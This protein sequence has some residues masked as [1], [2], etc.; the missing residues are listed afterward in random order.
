[1]VF[2]LIYIHGL[3][4]D[5]RKQN[6]LIEDLTPE[7]H[8]PENRHTR[9]QRWLQVGITLPLCVTL[10]GCLGATRLPKRTRTPEG[11]EVKN[12][13][14]SFLHPGQ[15]TRAEVKERLKLIDTGYQGDHFFLG[16]WSSSVWGAW[17]VGL[18]S[19][20]GGRVWKNGNLLVEFDDAGIV[21][22]FEPFDDTKAL[23]YLAPVAAGTPLQLESPLELPVKYW[24]FGWGEQPVDAKIVLSKGTFDFEELGKLKKK[25][26]FSLPASEIL[27]VEAPV[28]IR[29]RDPAPTYTSQTLRCA[30][31]LKK[32]GGPRGKDLNLD[33]MIPQLVTL[34]SYVSQ[35]AKSPVSA[36]TADRK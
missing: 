26:K 22:R 21:K 33:V 17:A 24:K 4:V 34:M 20:G 9:A 23:R 1:M 6:G 27:R 3:I 19:G 5:L 35:A 36:P 8:K 16:R 2:F 13:D 10:L 28:A 32:I 30:R 11:T 14:L 15:T 18:W 7:S 25:H 31:D 29:D 12:I